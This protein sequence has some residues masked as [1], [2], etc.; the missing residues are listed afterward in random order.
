MLIIMP[1]LPNNV[2]TSSNKNVLLRDRKRRT[3][4]ALHPSWFIA[5]GG[6]GGGVPQSYPGRR[7]EVPQSYPG[8]GRGKVV[9]QSYPGLGGTLILSWSG[10]YPNPGWGTPSPQILGY[11]L[12]RTWDQ[13]LGKGTGT[14]NW[15]TLYVHRKKDRCL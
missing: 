11:P 3:A 12:E 10:G 14:R 9:P 2:K 15:G 4:R 1:N 8:W 13:R 5:V 6:G 7:M